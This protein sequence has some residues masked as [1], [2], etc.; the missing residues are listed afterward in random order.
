[1]QGNTLHTSLSFSPSVTNIV[2]AQT[3]YVYNKETGLWIQHASGVSYNIA[4]YYCA[5]ITQAVCNGPYTNYWTGY[6]DFGGS[7]PSATTFVHGVGYQWV[8]YFS[9]LGQS[10]TSVTANIPN[11]QW[12]AKVGAWLIGFSVYLWDSGSQSYTIVF[13]TTFPEPVPSNVYNPLVL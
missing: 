1:M 10:D 12:D 5:D 13:P 2:A 7:T 4:G 11:A 3:N 9:P 6:L 8:Y